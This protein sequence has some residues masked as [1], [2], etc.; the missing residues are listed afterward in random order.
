MLLINAARVACHSLFCLSFFV[1]PFA[2]LR[3]T[4]PFP[5]VRRTLLPPPFTMRHPPSL[6][7]SS[8]PRGVFASPIDPSHIHIRSRGCRLCIVAEDRSLLDRRR[9]AEAGEETQR[10]HAGGRA[11]PPHAGS[12][13]I[14]V[15][16]G[17]FSVI[18]ATTVLLCVAV[19]V[20][21]A[22]QSFHAGYDV[23]GTPRLPCSIP[24]Q[25]SLSWIRL[26]RVWLCC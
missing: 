11:D 23:R 26:V 13:L 16:C 9:S 19:N 2:V 1:L 3:F 8:L 24:V 10:T 5:F 20:V 18:T 7:L 15:V 17:Y 14:L 12:N 25:L 4:V 22:T 6:A 21:S